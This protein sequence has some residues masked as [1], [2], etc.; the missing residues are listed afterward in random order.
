MDEEESD[1]KV[2]EGQGAAC[3]SKLRACRKTGG[4]RSTGGSGMDVVFRGLLF[5]SITK[6]YLNSDSFTIFILF[7]PPL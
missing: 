1:E 7:Y 5:C 4:K 2:K 6:E 3:E